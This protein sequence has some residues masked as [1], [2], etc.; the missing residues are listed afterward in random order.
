M[1]LPRCS[2]VGETSRVSPG[3][4]WRS[5]AIAI[6]T[7]IRPMSWPGTVIAS[8]GWRRLSAMFAALIATSDMAPG[9]GRPA[10][11]SA[12]TTPGQGGLVVHDEAR[13]LGVLREQL[14][15]HGDAAGVRRVARQDVHLGA[16]CASAWSTTPSRMRTA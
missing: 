2:S 5:R 9:T 14:V 3:L 12:S 8:T 13:H 15:D 1:T 11:S 7:A 10:R 6:S 16:R 4:S